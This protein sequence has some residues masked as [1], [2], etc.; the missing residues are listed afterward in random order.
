MLMLPLMAEILALLSLSDDFCCTKKFL[1]AIPCGLMMKKDIVGE[2][3][4]N[5][6]YLIT[7]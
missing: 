5:S 6:F 7:F 4:G 3:V 1:Q 2:G